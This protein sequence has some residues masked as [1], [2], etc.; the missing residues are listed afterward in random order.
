M[1]IVCAKAG[2]ELSAIYEAV[3]GALD[4]GVCATDGSQNVIFCNRK[5]LELF[6]LPAEFVAHEMPAS[7][8]IARSDLSQAAASPSAQTWF[9]GWNGHT[10]AFEEHFDM[11]GGT[12]IFARHRPLP[13]GNWI[14]VFEDRTEHLK[15]EQELRV[16]VERFDQAMTNMAHGLCMYSPDERLIVCNDKYIQLYSLDRTIV[17]PGTKYRDILEHSFKCG[18][19]PGQFLDEYYN[20]RIQENKAVTISRSM[21]ED[22]RVIEISNRPMPNGG[23]VSAHEDIT[24]RAQAERQLAYFAHYDVLTGLSNR[25]SFQT[26]MADALKGTGSQSDGFSL[27]CIDLDRFKAVNDTFGHPVGDKLLQVV[28]D[29]LRHVVRNGDTVARLGGDEF[30]ILQRETNFA[31]TDAL[32]QR[33]IDTIAQPISID[34]QMMTIG[35]SIGIAMAPIHGTTADA[36]RKNADTALYRAKIGGRGLYRFFDAEMGR[37]VA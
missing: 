30:A 34:G 16:Q 15:I 25:I 9:T 27:L 23:W 18:N 6:D 22:G 21:L 24:D 2:T 26:A 4:N 13:D 5:F 37:R 29:R 7:E 36:L 33:L 28:A 3:L 19:E 12:K 1:S 35:M 31:M 14:S 11:V 20:R 32:A 10:A 8:F 17:Q